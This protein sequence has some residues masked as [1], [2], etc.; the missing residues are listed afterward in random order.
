MCNMP[1][2]GKTIVLFRAPSQKLIQS[3]QTPERMHVYVGSLSVQ[4][5]IENI[6]VNEIVY[7]RITLK[8]QNFL[9]GA[10]KTIIPDS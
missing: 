2:N 5:I 3:E 4:H 1:F 8:W 7:A 6:Q 10:P 9:L